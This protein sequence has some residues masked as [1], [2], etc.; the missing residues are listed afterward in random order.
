MT[1]VVARKLHDHIAARKAARQP[2]RAHRGFRARIHEP[3]F[4]DARHGLDDQ[5]RQL[6]FR[7]RRRTK[8][9]ATARRFFDR[10]H[11]ARIR[12]PQNERPPRADVIDVAIAIDIPQIRSFTALNDN[13]L[14]ADAA[15]RPRRAVHPSRHQLP[16]PF[17][18]RV[19][20]FTF[21]F[22]NSAMRLRAFATIAS[23]HV[24]P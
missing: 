4:L 7:F 5:L 2:N 15:K 1:V 22:F 8:A 9:R 16:R 14:S 17:K 13:R 10:R 12:M 18:Q 20:S 6:I 3:H 24:S 11:D 21:H 19:T 23:A